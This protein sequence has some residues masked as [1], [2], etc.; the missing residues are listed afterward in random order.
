MLSALAIASSSKSNDEEWQGS[1]LAK[2]GRMVANWDRDFEGQLTRRLRLHAESIASPVL[3]VGAR[4]GAEVRAFRA[5]V[6]QLLAVGT[7]FNPG[8]R[9]PYVM[10]GDAHNLQF[11]DGSFALIYTNVLD[12]IR[13][14]SAFVREA[15]RCLKPGGIAWVEMDQNAPDD[16]AIHD[17]N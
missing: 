4:L 17:L 3:C 9:N 7:D 6:E 1:K 13:N 8:L 2:N 16:F 5:C 15:H 10:W 12:H 11:N 14:T